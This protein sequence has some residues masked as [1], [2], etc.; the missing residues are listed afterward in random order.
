M[1]LENM[2]RSTCVS[3]QRIRKG[4]TPQEAIGRSYCQLRR[5]E[6]EQAFVTRPPE[7]NE[8]E[9]VDE[10]SQ[11]MLTGRRHLMGASESDAWREKGSGIR[12][13]GT[14]SIKERRA[15]STKRGTG[16]SQKG[17]K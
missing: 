9:E 1:S 15:R 12:R 2:Y 5:G 11:T 13:S 10:H 6:D 14:D 3:R 8:S 17:Y 4:N 7:I 16:H